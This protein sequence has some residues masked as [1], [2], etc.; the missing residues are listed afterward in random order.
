MKHELL[1]LEREMENNF[2]IGSLK[3]HSYSNFFF[4]IMKIIY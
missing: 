1:K 4:I 2:S 3:G